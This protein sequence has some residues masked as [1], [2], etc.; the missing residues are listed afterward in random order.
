MSQSGTSGANRRL[1]YP[2]DARLLIVNA[3]DLGMYP[4]INEAIVRSCKDGIVR[5]TDFEFLTSPQAQA[6][7]RE[8]GIILIGYEPLQAVWRH[9]SS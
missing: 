7:I 5:S 8:E 6:V 4:A 3:D 9:R 2:D 1:G